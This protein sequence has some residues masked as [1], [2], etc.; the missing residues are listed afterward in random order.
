MT[1]VP[2]HQVTDVELDR[3]VELRV[4]YDDGVTARFPVTELRAN[5]PCAGCRGRREQGLDA[6]TTRDVNALGAELRGGW[7][8][9]IRWT[10]GHDTGIFS[11]ELLRGMWEQQRD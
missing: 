3:A 11:W 5:C 4:T 6:A 2:R 8:I 10:D 9:A 1:H 7:G